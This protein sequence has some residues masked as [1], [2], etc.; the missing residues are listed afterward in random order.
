MIL[1]YSHEFCINCNML[2][3]IMMVILYKWHTCI[4]QYL[5]LDNVGLTSRPVWKAHCV[6]QKVCVLLYKPRFPFLTVTR[7]MKLQIARSFWLEQNPNQFEIWYACLAIFFDSNLDWW[8]HIPWQLFYKDY[9]P[10]VTLYS[11]HSNHHLMFRCRCCHQVA[12]DSSTSNDLQ[13][14]DS[15]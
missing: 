12:V 13:T 14:G 6:D 5:F 3:Y 4:Y 1:K 2:L 15:D 10:H 11:S 9:V 8:N 7:S